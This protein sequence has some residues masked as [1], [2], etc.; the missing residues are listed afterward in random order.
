MES[1]TLK[2]GVKS[3]VPVNKKVD[4]DHLIYRLLMEILKL[5]A[6]ISDPVIDLMLEK[7]SVWFAPEVYQQMPVLLPWVVRDSKCRKPVDQWASPDAKGFLRDDNS[8]VKGI[9][10][11]LLIRG[12]KGSPL[13]GLKMGNSFVACHIWQTVAGNA[14]A[15]RDPQLNSFVPNLVWLPTQV[16]KLSDHDGGAVQNGLKRMSVRIY[17]S[18]SVQAHV[19]PAAAAAWAKLTAP[20]GMC[21]VNLSNVHFFDNPPK[22]LETREAILNKTSEFV[23]AVAAGKQLPSKGR[24]PTRY[25]EGLPAVNN[26]AVT[27]LASELSK[28]SSKSSTGV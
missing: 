14:L 4:G 16:A 1:R 26:A 22:F 18:L 20:S 15:T 17:G 5:P 19:A 6:A 2:P 10:R 11:S 27:V 24:I 9:P 25:F 13:N 8:L 28:Y 23:G 3:K 12:P 21:G 7:M